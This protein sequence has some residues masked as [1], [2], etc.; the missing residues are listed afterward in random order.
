MEICSQSWKDASRKS[1]PLQS[2]NFTWPKRKNISIN[3][4][5]EKINF[6]QYIEEWN[7]STN[8]KV[9]VLEKLAK[10][11]LTAISFGYAK[12]ATE[13]HHTLKQV[14]WCNIINLFMQ[15]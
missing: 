1:I 12:K 10:I 13:E 8:V 7:Q 5:M 11:Y 3:N 2:R 9:V 6:E 4:I 14:H 15:T